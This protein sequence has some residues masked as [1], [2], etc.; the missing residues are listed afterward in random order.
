VGEEER[1]A[2]I[3]QFGFNK[4]KYKKQICTCRGFKKEKYPRAMKSFEVLSD[5]NHCFD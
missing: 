4:E 2:N 1:Q 3:T 5:H